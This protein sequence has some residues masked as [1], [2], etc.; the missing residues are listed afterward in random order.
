MRQ[1]TPV[2]TVPAPFIR[3]ER[4]PS[5]YLMVYAALGLAVGVALGERMAASGWFVCTDEQL[6]PDP[7]WLLAPLPILAGFLVW[8]RGRRRVVIPLLVFGLVLVGIWRYAA[9]PF[10]P[11]LG[12]GDLAYYNRTD[13]YGGPS[14]MEGVITAYPDE[15]PSYTQ[16]RVQVDT[17]WQGNER[18]QVVGA[19]LVQA[20]KGAPYHYGDRVRVRGAPVAPPVFSDFDYRRYLAGK[21]IHTQVRQARITLLDQGQGSR[22]LA[23]LYAFRARASAILQ[24]LLPEPYAALAGGMILGIESGIPRELYAEFNLTGASHVIVISGSNIALVSAIFLAVFSRGLMGRKR[25]AA[26]FTLAGIIAYTLLVG[27]DSAV[28]RA[29]IMGGLF[30]LAMALGQQ[31]A[32][33]ISLFLAGLLMLALNPLT[34]WD[35]GFQLSFAATLGLILL[36]QPLLRRWQTGTGGRLPKF[37]RG[38]VAE[39]LLITVAAQ[40]ATLPLIVSYFGRLSLISVLVNLLIVPVQPLILVGGGLSVLAG[41]AWLPLA[42]LIALAPHAGLWWTTAVVQRGAAIPFASL[43][44]DAFGR[45]IALLCAV[46][47][48][49]AFLWWLL[50]QEQG[51]TTLLPPA[52]RRPVQRSAVLAGAIILPLWLG[53]TYRE[54]QPDGRL[55]IHL[56]GRERAADFFLVTPNGNTALVTTAREA[57]GYPISDLLATLPGHRCPDLALFAR[58]TPAM[59]VLPECPA[60][61]ILSPGHPAL[62]ADARL[63]LDE[64]VTLTQLANAGDDAL[65]FL[66]RYKDFTT[67]LPFEN[68]QETQNGLLTSLPAGLTLL[69][70]PFAGTGAWPHPDLLAHLRPEVTLLPQG[71]TYPP[72]VLAELNEKATATIPSDAATEIT[73]D[74]RS[75]TLTMRPY[76]QDNPER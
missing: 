27:A 14:V 30:V 36:G 43:E 33:L 17:L 15:R 55:H 73:T 52:W 66:L 22:V 57:P 19:A 63:T 44:I 69:P 9:H 45:L 64:G 35:V 47:F 26:V 40:I 38:L 59:P 46:L 20:D 12:P 32:A 65:L 53:A 61:A 41:L 56:L 7:R 34:L 3:S 23:A 28:T 75:F 74:G 67:L 29:A 5:P 70:A 48:V 49:L 51:A 39:G 1:V 24:S 13:P 37:T 50:R 10:E 31:S 11:C 8:G 42:R 58:Q 2:S 60:A 76:P 21:A 25:L 62:Q 6:A 4:I 72:S 16:Y 54:A 18:L 68:S 71:A